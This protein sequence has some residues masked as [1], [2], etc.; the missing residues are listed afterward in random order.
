MR[1]SA[2]KRRSKSY[3]TRWVL[4]IWTASRGPR[5]RCSRRPTNWVRRC[6]RPRPARPQGPAGRRQSPRARPRAATRAS[7]RG[8]GRRTASPG[9]APG[10]GGRGAGTPEVRG[11]PEATDVTE[12]ADAPRAAAPS[13]EQLEA[14]VQR[15]KAQAEQHWQQFLHAAADLENYKKQ[16]ARAREDAVERTRRA[17][18]TVILSVV[19]NIERALE[20]GGQGDAAASIIEG[21]RM[22]HRQILDLLANMGVR[23]F[24]TAGRLFDA[25]YHEAVEVVAPT[26]H[27]TGTVVAEV[28]RGYLIGDEVLRPARVRVAREA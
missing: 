22:T 6:T 18:L 13:S 28:Q 24:D 19:D 26:E 12:T 17:M 9:R 20:Y 10:G 27:P 11:E 7:M 15:Y 23:P 8:T 14:E 16:A 4:Q 2:W 1:S 25:R 3:A 5:R 21:I